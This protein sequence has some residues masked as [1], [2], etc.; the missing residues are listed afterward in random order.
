[1]YHYEPP[2][3]SGQTPTQVR[4]G[5]RVRLLS[6]NLRRLIPEGRL[7][8]TEGRLHFLRKV[9]P[10]GAIE[11]LNDVWHVGARWSGEYVRATINTQQQRL[12][13]W[14]K[15]SAESDWQLIKTRCFRL[16]ETVHALRPEFR[17]NCTRCRDCLPG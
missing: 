13:F 7:P 1:M 14:H 12:S 4:R 11:M 2:A 5:A 10:S 3:L 9:D 8:L 15:R 17:R 16:K 6:A